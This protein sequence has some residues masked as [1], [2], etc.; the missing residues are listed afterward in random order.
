[1]ALAPSPFLAFPKLSWVRQKQREGD[2]PRDPKQRR[3]S[4]ERGFVVKR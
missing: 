4:M 1:M 3:R 2:G